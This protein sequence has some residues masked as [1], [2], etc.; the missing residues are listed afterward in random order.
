MLTIIKKSM[1]K[2]TIHTFVRITYLSIVIQSI[3]INY[4][5]SV[6]IFTTFFKNLS[7]NLFLHLQF[8]KSKYYPT[9]HDLPYSQ[10][11]LLGFQINPLSDIPLSMNS[12][13][14]HICIYLYSNDYYYKHLHLIYI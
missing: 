1:T 7:T 3:I 5:I 10:S 8:L 6:N 4:F 14:I 9:S 12:L 2:N 13:Y 11:Q